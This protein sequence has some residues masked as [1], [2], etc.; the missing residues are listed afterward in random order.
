M[1]PLLRDYALEIT[2][3]LIHE[4]KSGNTGTKH[5]VCHLLPR[6]NKW[7]QNKD[8]HSP[9]AA[10]SFFTKSHLK[11]TLQRHRGITSWSKPMR[12]IYSMLFQTRGPGPSLPTCSSFPSLCNETL[13][14]E[15]IW[16]KNSLFT[17]LTPPVK[18]VK[19]GNQHKTCRRIQLAAFLICPRQTCLGMVPPTVGYTLPSQSQIQTVLHKHG[20][21]LW[22]LRWL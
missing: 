19:A 9:S 4:P 21:C 5:N 11:W 6:K 10:P 14:P 3:E 12:N 22:S 7:S 17:L 16:R 15:A 2:S 18:K 1:L 8:K 20:H 13:W